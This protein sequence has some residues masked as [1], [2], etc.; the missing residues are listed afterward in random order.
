MPDASSEG[1]R[2]YTTGLLA[3]PDPDVEPVTRVDDSGDIAAPWVGGVMVLAAGAS[4]RHLVERSL[5]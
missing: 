1:G 5:A 4:E 3:A 2:S